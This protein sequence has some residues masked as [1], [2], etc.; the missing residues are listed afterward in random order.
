M[1]N[2]EKRKA[3]LELLHDA[4]DAMIGAELDLDDFFELTNDHNAKAYIVDPLKRLA[5][6]AGYLRMNIRG[7]NITI[8]TL[9]A[10]VNAGDCDDKEKPSL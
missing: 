6:D 3:L 7:R 4:Q 9:I 5:R 10:R 8:D 1:S 2:E